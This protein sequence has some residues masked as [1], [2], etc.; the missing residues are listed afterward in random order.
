MRFQP[1]I[2][3]YKIVYDILEQRSW[4]GRDS[5]TYCPDRYKQ[6]R[7]ANE[8]RKEF[9]WHT[10]TITGAG[11]PRPSRRGEEGTLPYLGSGAVG[12]PCRLI[13]RRTV[14]RAKRI[15]SVS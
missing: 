4:K 7:H 12:S 6:E 11:C 3:C 13:W 8:H 15:A 9:S 5:D 2:H 1:A 10:F 14:R